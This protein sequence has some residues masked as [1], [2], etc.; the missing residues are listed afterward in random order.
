MSNRA[1]LEIHGKS[2]FTQSGIYEVE[3]FIS[4]S[5]PAPDK[6]KN[7]QFPSLWK[8]HF[9]LRVKDGLF[10]E[11]LGS[12]V[13]PIPSSVYALDNAWI[14]VVDLFSSLHSIFNVFFEKSSD[15]NKSE[16]ISKTKLSKQA[17]T[18]KTNPDSF[19]PYGYGG[20]QGDK[21]STGPHGISGDKG[22]Q[23]DKG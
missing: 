19:K 15:E 2:P 5:K 21:G 16:N 4:D 11:T 7:K 20:P 12:D 6:I 14:I 8:G 3:I 17:D 18:V 23:G 13:N 22:P 1:R 9:H 10:T